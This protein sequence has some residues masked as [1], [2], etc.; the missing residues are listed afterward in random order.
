[1]SRK[2]VRRTR[3]QNWRRKEFPRKIFVSREEWDFLRD[4]LKNPPPINEGLRRLFEMNR[5]KN[6]ID[7]DFNGATT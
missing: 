5:G 6:W 1:V 4:L 3:R 7:I 2:Q